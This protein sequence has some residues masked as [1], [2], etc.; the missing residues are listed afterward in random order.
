MKLMMI[1]RKKTTVIVIS[2]AVLVV[3]IAD[4]VLKKII[5]TMP[6]IWCFASIEGN[7]KAEEE[8]WL[9]KYDTINLHN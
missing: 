9:V 6:L 8:A 4:A 2:V 1:S 3:I 5:F 7:E